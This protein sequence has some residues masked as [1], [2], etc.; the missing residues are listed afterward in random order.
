MSEEIPT[1]IG[2]Y[3]PR[4]VL[5]R[6]GMGVVYE[7][8]HESTGSRVALKTVRVQRTGRLSQIRREVQSLARLRHP[9]IVQVVDQG[10]AGVIPWYAMQLLE[11]RTLAD[12][13]RTSFGVVPR[14][15]DL[16]PTA[17]TLDREQ[18][19]PLTASE[20]NLSPLLDATPS[21]PR[22]L[23]GATAVRP[24]LPELL[25]IA[26]R[27]A[28]V[29]EYVHGEGIV[30]RDVKPSNVFVTEGGRPVLVD[31][32]LATRTG[33]ASGR[34]VL[35]FDALT[36]GSA[37]YMAPEQ[38][39]GEPLDP[40]CDLYSFGCLLFE[41]V[42]G[43]PPFIGP[44]REVVDQHLRRPP[45]RLSTIVIGAPAELDRLI[46]GMLR[47]DR[48]ERAG[49]ARDVAAALERWHGASWSSSPPR[50]RT[51]L[52]RP[53][54]VGR[55]DVISRFEPSLRE[56]R[57]GAGRITMVQGESGVGK[58]R[59]ALEV[60]RIGNRLGARVVA[61]ACSLTAPESSTTRLASRSSP[62]EPLRPLLRA[63]ADECLEENEGET[64]RVVRTTAPL[65]AAFE[66]ALLSVPGCSTAPVIELP[67]S[68]ARERLS[69]TL[70][71]VLAAFTKRSPLLL[72]F[73]D[74]Q[75]ADEHTLHFLRYL[76]SGYVRELP[77]LVLGVVRREE[78][79]DD[80][81]ALARTTGV[82][83]I[84]L[85]RLQPGD[86]SH[87][88]AG[89]L[90]LEAAA[91]EFVRFLSQKSEGNALF[92]SEYMRIAVA[93]QVLVRD[94]T[95]RWSLAQ[96]DQPTSALC[97]SL[98]LP[99]SLREILERRLGGLDAT[100]EHLLTL[101]AT[102]GRAFELSVLQQSAAVDDTTA[103]NAIADLVQR[104]IV[105]EAHDAT[106][107]RFTHDKL[108][109]ISY[110]SLD[111][112][113][114]SAAHRRVADVLERRAGQGVT[115][116]PADIGHH[117]LEAGEL[118]RSA[119]HLCEAGERSLRVSALDRAIAQF[120]AAEGVLA[121][122]GQT[123]QLL[124]VRES[125]GDALCV[126][127][128]LT[129]ARSAFSLALEDV[130]TQDGLLR[131][132]LLRKSGKTHELAHEHEKA[133][134]LYERAE[135]AL[136]SV[137]QNRAR[138]SEWIRLQRARIWIYY[139]LA[140]VPEM[141]ASVEALR[142]YI[143]ADAS[144]L[145]R[146]DY[147]HALA[148]YRYRACRYRISSDAIEDARRSL[149]AAEE[150][151]TLVEA[152]FVRFTL[153]FGLLFNGQ[154]Q[155]AE[156]ELSRAR[157]E[158]CRLGDTMNEVRC[159]AYLTLTHRRAHRVGSTRTHAEETLQRALR[160]NMLDY[161]G[162]ARACLGWAALKSGD[163][164]EARKFTQ[165][166]VDDWS[167]LTFEYPFQW[168]GLLTLLALQLD[169]IP[170]RALISVVT[171]LLDVRLAR[172]PESLEESLSAAVVSYSAGK[173]TDTREHLQLALDEAG[174][175]GLV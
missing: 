134:A 32:G 38:I 125:L 104:Q 153:G 112:R 160:T 78:R 148:S 25:G 6:G 7:A 167:T 61:S 151:N 152:A 84:D 18:I 16:A 100:T 94:E 87:M 82:E 174:A 89:M 28:Q 156:A 2:P 44:L 36:A 80:L 39:R 137:G 130:G 169:H 10:V 1:Q 73:D 17:P 85:P 158:S 41:L 49:Y 21:E 166:A 68:L 142:P 123:Q 19:G 27:L 157:V 54:L 171:K 79:G 37:R 155:P 93:E 12:R 99:Q 115:V 109:E 95:G 106:G 133:L 76:A 127:G 13:I 121:Q 163:Y 128:A 120:R 90:S 170:L 105:E 175:A 15:D 66:P 52:Y 102:I 31:F 60:A 135:D 113:S 5:G 110:A 88:V 53:P 91:P 55:G 75:W 146:S 11:G 81:T 147:Y 96:S 33:D 8:Q 51:Y 9:G 131:A 154:L 40:R 43:R 164:N 97:E 22:P 74:L 111:A 48:R 47:K 143:D 126:T 173:H 150:A 65:L 98:P 168:T 83:C 24:D 62:L 92:V 161:A 172:L 42:T 107:F 116:D 129:A 103:L 141:N 57:P 29:L 46:A 34:D 108:R 26:R 23:L 140:R 114:R 59:V 69:R 4:S 145:D 14:A 30:H 159:L 149:A 56:L 72:I 64:A 67:A 136:P 119:P 45:P 118:E 3:R 63:I 101:A 86:V 117:W 165:Q 124:Q 144:P 77:V 50:A 58:T 122:L 71:E 132:R 20:T 162:L 70:Y 35:D 138:I 139:W